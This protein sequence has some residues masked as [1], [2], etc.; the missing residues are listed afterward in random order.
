MSDEEQQAAVAS[1]DEEVPVSLAT[2]R[3]GGAPAPWVE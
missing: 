2:E 1:E 3:V